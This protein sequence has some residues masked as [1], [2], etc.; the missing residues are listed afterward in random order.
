[1]NRFKKFAAFFAFALMML[2]LPVVASAQWRDDRRNDDDY[3][4][5][6]RYNNRALKATIKN[7]KNHS[8]QFEKTLDR[9]LDRSRYDNR[10][11][12]DAL[13]ELAERFFDATK[14][15]DDEYDNRRDYRDSYDEARRVLNLGSQLDRALSRTRLDY[16]VQREW[17]RIRYDLNQ[18]AD[19][20]QY[21][22]RY[23]R[24]DDYRRS[25]RDR[26][27]DYRRNRRDDDY[28]RS[29][30]N[31]DWRRHIPFPFPF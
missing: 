16:S 13:N 17:S 14:D 3:Y 25:R 23:R 24:D 29:R 18:L 10:R 22:D 11:R 27:D 12:E 19:A 7:L 4:R 8:K 21:D 15:L 20:Y 1:M 9:A 5:N 2:T 31:D 28:G 6:S 26:D 30:R